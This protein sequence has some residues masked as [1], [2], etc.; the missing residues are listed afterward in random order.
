MLIGA[1][2]RHGGAALACGLGPDSAL[3]CL[4]PLSGAPTFWPSTVQ[5]KIHMLHRFWAFVALDLCQA[6]SRY[7]LSVLART[8]G[9]ESTKSAE[10]AE[11]SISG[12]NTPVSSP[13]TTTEAGT[14]S[15]WSPTPDLAKGLPV[16]ANGVQTDL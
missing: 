14:T 12:E 10:E 2:I 11:L 3:S 4:D 5:A 16:P 6:D 13:G 15:F 9:L 8:A 7:E 1:F